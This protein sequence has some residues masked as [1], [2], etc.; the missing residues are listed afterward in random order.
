MNAIFDEYSRGYDS[1]YNT[2]LGAF[3]DTL[4]TECAFS[5][6]QPKRGMRVLDAGCGTGNFTIKLAKMGVSVVGIDISSS[7]LQLAEEKNVKNNLNSTFMNADCETIS[8]D[9]NA[10]FDGI[11]SIAAFEFMENPL[12]VYTNLKQYLK[13]GAPFVIGTIQKGSDW[14]T[15][16]ASSPFKD[17]VYAKANFLSL[18]NIQSF[19]RECYINSTQCLFIP[20]NEKEYNRELETK[21]KRTI[22]RGGFLCVKFLKK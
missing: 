12:N 9:K 17:T 10:Q 22:E 18:E 3:V 5:L 1:W 6:L 11:I 19:D 21:Y 8:F 20:P 7:M 2:V 16:Y 13:I 4:E 15:L 14:H